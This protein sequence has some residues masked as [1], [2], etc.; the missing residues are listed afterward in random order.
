MKS[1]TKLAFFGAV[2][3]AAIALSTSSA[4]ASNATTPTFPTYQVPPHPLQPLSA[5][6]KALLKN[7]SVSAKGGWIVAHLQGTPF[8][9][10][11]QNGYL[12]AQSA[13]YWIQV[14]LGAAG[15]DSRQ[16]GDAIAKD[17]VWRKVPLEYRL[18]MEGIHAGLQ[19]AGYAKDTLWDVVAA[20]DW[21]DQACYATVI[22]G[23]RVTTG[24][25]TSLV[26]RAAKRGCSAFIATGKATTD[27]RP[28]MGHNTWSAYDQDF[29][30]NVMFYVH[31]QHGYTFAYQSAGGQIWSGQDWYENSAGLMLTETSLADTTY[32]PAG[33][34]TFVRA[35]E[36][37][38][39][40]SS[41]GQVVNTL[42]SGN[43]GAY[44]NEWLIGD[45]SGEI[46]SLQMG[47]TAYDL[48][49]THSGFF[50]SSNYDWGAATR[51]EEGSAADPADPANDDYAR[52]VRW[53]QLKS[54][55]FGR[56]T[57]TVGKTMESDTYDTYLG[58]I[59]PD[60]RTICGEPENGS[61]GIP[62]S[63]NND[64]GAY[65]G[66]V[67]TE[68]MVLNGLQ[69]WARWGHPNGDSFSATLFLQHNP[70]WAS[71]NGPLA[72]FGL[73]TFAAQTPNPW[74]LLRW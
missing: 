50:G 32:H 48:S 19:A 29:M 18:E 61:T 38:Q 49:V 74:V 64:G 70:T 3:C 30:Y 65:D 5:H 72:V 71:D 53:G 2:V 34:P 55:Y 67:C 10:G 60:E 52:Y 28:V 33:T 62:Y 40:D 63:G 31:P 14:D 36:A 66:K 37:A 35:R 15:S 4:F 1:L 46:A 57:S 12:T 73:K 27:G 6:V 69:M 59:C 26:N 23:P 56:I 39:Y 45:R 51:A 41:V 20:N 17:V 47:C 7:S 9:V 43:N 22:H 16:A 24:F 42:L 68:S 11:F 21:A 8:Q 44:C 13:D 58:K 54:E 25:E